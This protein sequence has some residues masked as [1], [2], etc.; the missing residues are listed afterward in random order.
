MKRDLKCLFEE[1]GKK[2]K[3]GP[4]E[5]A[6]DFEGLSAKLLKHHVNLSGSSL[7]KLWE[8][9]T[10]KRKL[11]MAAKNRL[12]RSPE[13]QKSS[14]YNKLRFELEVQKK[15]VQKA[16]VQKTRRLKT[17]LP[18]PSHSLL[19]IVVTGLLDFCLQDFH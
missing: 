10:G 14:H 18:M 15:E 2:S 7:K 4:H 9:V 19:L 17:E 1:A 11:S 6:K 3:V 8:L 12:A 13:V 5:L 16:E